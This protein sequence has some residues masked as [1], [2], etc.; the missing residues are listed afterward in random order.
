MRRL[1]VLLALLCLSASLHA[2]GFRIWN[3]RNHPELRWQKLETPHFRIVYPEHLTA[4]AL[5]TAAIAES[6]RSALVRAL[7]FAPRRKLGV[8]LIDSDEIAN[9]YAS[10]TG[11]AFIWAHALDAAE[12]FSGPEKWLRKVVAHEVAHLMHFE[13]TRTRLGLWGYVL[14]RPLPRAFAE[15]LAQ[16]WTESWDALRG[17]LWLRTA[18]MDGRLSYAD[19][20][21]AWSGRLLY[22]VGHSQIRY[23]AQQRGDSAIA[24]LLKWRS[25]W[26]LYDFPSAFRTATGLSPAQFEEEWRRAVLRY[27]NAQAAVHDALPRGRQDR[28]TLGPR[29]VH[30]VRYSRDTQWV[31]LTGLWDLDRPNRGLWVRRTQRGSRFRLLA[32]GVEPHFA[33]HPEGRAVVY[34][35]FVRGAHG[36]LVRDLFATELATGRTQRLTRNARAAH[37][38]WSPD[39]SWIV[40]VRAEGPAANLWRIRADGTQEEPLTRFQDET[41]CLHPRWSPDGRR[42]A[43]TLFDAAGNRD[44]AVLDLERRLVFVLTSDAADD[45]GP[46]WS[47]DGRWIA[48]TSFRDAIPNVYRICSDGAAKPEAL[49]RFAYGTQV[50]AWL[51]SGELVLIVTASK[52]YDRVYRLQ[53]SAAPPGTASDSI[54]MRVLSRL[55]AWTKRRPPVPLASS[56]PRADSGLVRTQGPYVSWRHVQPVLSGL[57][58]WYGSNRH[59]GLAGLSLWMEPLGKHMLLGAFVLN[60]ARPGRSSFLLAYENAQLE[61]TIAISAGRLP[62]YLSLSP[63]GKLELE[64]ATQLELDLSWPVNA[65]ETPPRRAAWGLRLRHVRYEVRTPE[66]FLRWPEPIRPQDG[67]ASELILWGMVRSE[68]PYRLASVLPQRAYGLKLAY[69]LSAPL[70]GG[71]SNRFRVD[72]D[73][74]LSHPVG[75]GWVLY[76]RILGAY[77]AGADLPREYIGFSRGDYV[78]IQPPSSIWPARGPAGGTFFWRPRVRGYRAFAY[79][80]RLFFGTLEARRLLLP[81]LQ[82]VLLGLAQLGGLSG[83]LF[84]EAG[85]VWDRYGSPVSRRAG[86]G[87]E[88]K[89][90]LRLGAFALTHA[91]GVAWALAGEKGARSRELYYR[92]QASLPVW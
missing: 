49:T 40:Y 86:T 66:I 63:D 78:T 29:Y 47:P 57:L 13:A 3:G 81:H 19:G 53:P 17:D 18:A 76:G 4:L 89:N 55:G 58:P 88:L 62:S 74:F 90:E 37:P 44:I 80:D 75:G 64:E 68:E 77:R 21:S 38:D 23:L 91:F 54:G 10:P 34:A 84:W 31:A 33:L 41:Q 60:A 45:R 73:A 43:F 8:Y 24:R 35:R 92:V 50:Q 65:L 27:Y 25:R 30:Q 12:L 69:R 59:W 6:T 83:A 42:I 82:S 67:S 32:M 52:E 36:E 26:G 72:A 70:L 20:R 5:P 48:F 14:G 22:A 15:G 39:G 79:G 87:L 9:G 61:P 46:V 51:P 7:G 11:N 1:I 85:S 16:Y 28:W 56:P 71:T 2:Q